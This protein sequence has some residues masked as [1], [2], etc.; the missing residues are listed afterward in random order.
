MWRASSSGFGLP[1]VR[2]LGVCGSGCGGLR[3]GRRG[4]GQQQ[5]AGV[6]LGRA[7]VE[8]LLRLLW[9]KRWPTNSKQDK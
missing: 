9:L 2:R 6:E 4:Y 8:I 1:L 5:G 3:G 7:M